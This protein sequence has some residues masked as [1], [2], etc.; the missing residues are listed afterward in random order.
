MMLRRRTTENDGSPNRRRG[1]TLAAATVVA[2][3]LITGVSYAYWSATGTGSATI[4][5]TTVNGLVVSSITTPLN[6]LYPGKTDDLGYKVTN[7]NVY[8]VQL[9]ALTAVSVTSSDAVNCPASNITILAAAQ[10]G[11]GQ[12]GGWT[13]ITPLTVPGNN[14]SAT[15]TLTNLVTMSTGAPV[16]CAGKT[17]TVALS[18]S[19]TQQ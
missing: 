6:D 5:A 14:G 3:V 1:W 9:T 16:L 18:F 2:G 12:P 10:T 7:G 19:G 17:F 11:V 13:G 15:G 8:A 4:Q